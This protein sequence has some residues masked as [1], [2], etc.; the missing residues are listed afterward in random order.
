MDNG[1][2]ALSAPDHTLL[3]P[4]LAT[5]FPFTSC[6]PL[7]LF[8]HLPCPALDCLNSQKPL[9]YTFY[10]FFLFYNSLSKLHPPP[11]DLFIFH[12]YCAYIFTFFVS[13]HCPSSPRPVFLLTV[14]LSAWLHSSRWDFVLC[15]FSLAVN[16]QSFFLELFYI[17]SLLSQ[18]DGETLLVCM[19]QNVRCNV[20]FTLFYQNSELWS[21]CPR[22][23]I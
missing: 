6:C 18:Q 5:A 12:V 15:E 11:P 2:H 10:V 16:Q 22:Y 9:C 17:Q 4:A 13:S 1:L 23:N 20:S 14:C 21:N 8:L 19:V 3:F 7:F